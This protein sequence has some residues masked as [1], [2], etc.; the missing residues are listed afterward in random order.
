MWIGKF[1]QWLRR[2]LVHHCSRSLSPSFVQVVAFG[3]NCGA[4]LN[5][6]RDLSPRIFQVLAGYGLDALRP[7]SWTYWLTG[8]IVGPHLGGIFGA[9]T[10]DKVLLYED[11]I[12]SDDDSK[13]TR[14]NSTPI[15]ESKH[16][17]NSENLELQNTT[18][19]N[20]DSSKPFLVV[21]D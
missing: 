11:E 15:K 4:A 1:S 9:W 6:A 19:L 12:T 18:T 2:S 14:N 13:T 10:F 20:D 21:N 16:K 5:P 7:L 17:N 3:L 8:G